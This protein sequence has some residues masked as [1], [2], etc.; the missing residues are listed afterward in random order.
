MVYSTCTLLTA[1]NDGVVDAFLGSEL[2][3]CFED[4]L[5]PEHVPPVFAAWITGRGRLQTLPTEGGPDGHY[6]AVLKRCT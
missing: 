4:A 6:A 1:E 2:G 3:S 5:D